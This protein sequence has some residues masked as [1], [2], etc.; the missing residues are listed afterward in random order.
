VQVRLQ[1]VVIQNVTTYGTVIDVPNQL[2]K[3]KPGMTATVK[4]EIAKRSDAL[5]V[6]NASL[7]FRP[8]AEV[9][10]ALNQ[11][12]PPEAQFAGGGRGGQ[13]GG[14]GGRGGQG[15]QSGAAA[16]GSPAPGGGPSA[17]SPSPAA[18]AQATAPGAGGAP[19]PATP[20][21]ARSTGDG[22]GTGG[23][24]GA[25]DQG[26]SASRGT[27]GDRTG[28]DGGGRFGGGGGGGFGRGGGADDPERKARMMERFKGM[29][30]DEQKQFIE[31]I[32]S[33]GQ[34]AGEFEKLMTKPAAARPP[35]AATAVR[36]KYGAPQSAETI[37][38]LFAP[39]PTIESRGRVWLF[40]NKELKPVNVRT[41][42]T[43]GTYTELLSG[44]LQ[45]NMEVVTGVILG[46]ARPTATAPGAGNPM[47]PNQRG[48]PGGFGGP[49]GGGGG[50]GR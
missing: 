48:G 24:R 15:G 32:K 43:D 4:V 16:T 28:G 1:P 35:S 26:M 47:M 46:S 13:G 18:S 17:A 21:S 3:L 37:D 41:G 45:Q 34:D 20:G 6:P 49:G 33:R 30:A 44:E 42:I 22:R 2:Y 5:R 25:G 12:V 40:M 8:T 14:R 38:A 11:A 10:T 23:G 9:F 19:Q 27:G 31:R 50:R 7:R 36:T 29:S 39:L